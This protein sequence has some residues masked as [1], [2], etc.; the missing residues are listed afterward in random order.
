MPDARSHRGAHPEDAELFSSSAEPALR[1]AAQDLRWL[2]DRGYAVISSVKLVGDRYALGARQRTAVTRGTCSMTAFQT[3]H[4]K[5]IAVHEVAGLR[6]LIDG[7]NLL[8][9]VEAALAGGVI[10]DCQDECFR[11]M[12]SMHGTWKRVEETGPALELVGQSLQEWK[13]ESC[14]WLLDSPVSNSG[15]LKVLVQEI[16][17]SH[18][19][20]WTVELV[21]DPDRIL[22]AT[23]ELTITAD[24]MILDR[25]S[26]W[27]NA[28][29]A[30]VSNHVPHAWLVDLS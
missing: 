9:T 25:C 21:P 13:L 26:C 4:S 27:T 6:V 2:L 19:W 3:R 11:D 10:L 18:G 23:P 8:T 29:K 28:A 14:H 12:A 22:C 17:K 7:Y 5:Q 1:N 15:R 24:S 16:A 30:I 20:N